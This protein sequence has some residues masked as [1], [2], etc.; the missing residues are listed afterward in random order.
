MRQW[1]ILLGGLVVWAA[2]FF[3]AYIAASLFPG[4]DTARWLTAGA[5]VA[6]LAADGAILLWTLRAPGVGLDRWIRQLG[7]IGATLSLVAVLWQGLPALLI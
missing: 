7:A 3:A 2:H 4:S 1:A 5:T 6:A